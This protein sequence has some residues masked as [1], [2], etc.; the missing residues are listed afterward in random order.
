MHFGHIQHLNGFKTTVLEGMVPG[1]E[2]KDRPAWRGTQDT[3]DALGMKGHEA[4]ERV[5]NESF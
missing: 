4:V 1:R 5:R 3:K 2:D